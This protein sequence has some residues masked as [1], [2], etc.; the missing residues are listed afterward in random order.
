MKPKANF[1]LNP[2]VIDAIR[3][4][5]HD[6]IQ[7]LCDE[8]N[9]HPDIVTSLHGFDAFWDGTYGE[10]HQVEIDPD[11]VQITSK[12]KGSF[13]AEFEV[14]YFF[15]C[16]DLNSSRDESMTFEFEIDIVSGEILIEGEEVE[17]RSPD[18]L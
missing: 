4:N 2:V 16:D 3:N 5:T 15:S 12:W 10:V 18:E 13:N 14:S 9:N 1:E 17:E 11:S 7:L 8:L 6:H